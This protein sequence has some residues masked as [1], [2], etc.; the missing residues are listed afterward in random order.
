M[1]R[2]VLVNLK[3]SQRGYV[4]LAFDQQKNEGIETINRSLKSFQH[5]VNGPSS[6]ISEVGKGRLNTNTRKF[7]NKLRIKVLI[8]VF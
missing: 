4:G 5:T 3:P 8:A 2:R 1:Y 6:T 7:N